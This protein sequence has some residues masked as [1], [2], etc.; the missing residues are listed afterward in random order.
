MV[1]PY[2]RVLSSQ[3]NST[4]YY[5]AFDG[6]QTSQIFVDQFFGHFNLL[7]NFLINTKHKKGYSA[8]TTL[9]KHAIRPGG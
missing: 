6:Y 3:K 8:K 2:F 1:L 9:L 4:N 7:Q 5:I